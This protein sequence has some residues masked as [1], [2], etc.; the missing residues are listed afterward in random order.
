MTGLCQN[1]VLEIWPGLFSSVINNKF[2]IE[3]PRK[4]H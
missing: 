4:F 1:L 3:N 2:K